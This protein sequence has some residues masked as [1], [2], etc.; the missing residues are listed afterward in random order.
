[1]YHDHLINVNDFLTTYPKDIARSLVVGPIITRGEYH[2]YTRRIETRGG[3]TECVRERC[4]IQRGVASTIYPTNRT[5]RSEAQRTRSRSPKMRIYLPLESVYRV[6]TAIKSRTPISC[7]CGCVQITDIRKRD[8]A[9]VSRAIDYNQGWDGN[10]RRAITFRQ[11][12]LTLSALSLLCVRSFIRC[13]TI[14]TLIYTRR[15]RASGVA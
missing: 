9:I 13:I 8:N 11:P 6:Y 4:Y 1:M 15:T 2:E 14:I 7:I 5:T 3:M 10:V 12:R